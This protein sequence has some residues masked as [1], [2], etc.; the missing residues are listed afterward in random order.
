VNTRGG[1]ERQADRLPTAG[2]E[3]PGRRTISIHCLV[4]ADSP[5]LGGEDAQHIKV[6]AEAEVPLPPILVHRATMRV[7]DGMHRLRAAILKGQNSVEVCF[8]DGTEDEAFIAAVK[9]NIS[10]GLPLTLSDRQAAAERI[11]RS[12]PQC[13]DRWIANIT[14]LAAGTVG[15]IRRRMPTGKRGMA[16]IGRDGRIRPLSSAEGRQIASDEIARRPDAS[17]REIARV[18]GISPA[19]VRDVR[20]RLRRGDIP[21]PPRRDDRPPP[22]PGSADPAAPE[23]G[24]PS[25]LVHD[26]ETL[27]QDLHKDPSLRHTESGRALLRWLH[28]RAGGPG[29]WEEII[30]EISPHAF[31]TVAKLARYCAEEW[32]HVAVQLEKRLQAMEG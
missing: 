25:T 6:L 21:V 1:S 19:T 4:A 28:D 31:Y 18:A 17:L 23:G 8:F 3:A 10:H 13:S 30:N 15:S 29:M 20:E 11:V 9:S 2:P 24:S 27:L 26:R 32:L 12:N 14:G 7:I 5:R 16:R 22:G